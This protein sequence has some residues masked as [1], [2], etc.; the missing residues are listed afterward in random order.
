LTV[1]TAILIPLTIGLVAGFLG[2]LL[3]I[4]GGSLITPIL[5][6][7]GYDIKTVIP[8]SLLAIVGTS[9]G[10]LDIYERENLINYR[11]GIRLEAT[12]VLGSLLGVRLALASSSGILKVI[13]AGVLV[14]I[15]LTTLRKTLND[16]QV[17]VENVK[18]SRLPSTERQ[19]AAVL[20]SIIKGMVSALAG[21]GGG[22]LGVPIL[23]R[24]L[25]LP[26]K[27]AIATSKL[28]VGI[29]A[30]A[31]ALSYMLKGQLDPCLGLALSIGTII[32]GIGGSK[33]GVSISSRSVSIL[34]ALFL[35]TMAAIILVRR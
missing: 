18:L 8:A 12:S 23:N 11:I 20:A 31:G 35:I 5:V 27:E 13:L 34:F 21:I 4:G 9:I 14:Y 30:A 17:R 28:L 25:K 16:K 24:I 19:V 32:G 6:S 3:G 26:I 15:G 7:L 22:I 1:E 10:G 2:S 33:T 29:T